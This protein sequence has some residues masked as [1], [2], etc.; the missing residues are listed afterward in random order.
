VRSAHGRQLKAT[1]TIPEANLR[2]QLQR[3]GAFVF[4]VPPGRYTLKVS[5]S[6]HRTQSKSF[7]LAGGEE[8]IFSIELRRKR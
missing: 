5:A 2:N 6:G 3:N 1:V 8:S 7:E 4:E